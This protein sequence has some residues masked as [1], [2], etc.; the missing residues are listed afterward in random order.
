MSYL[1]RNCFLILFNYIFSKTPDPL[2]SVA[3]NVALH[4]IPL[5]NPAPGDLGGGGCRELP[6]RDLSQRKEFKVITPPPVQAPKWIPG[7]PPPPIQMSP[8]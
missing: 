1:Q 8:S 4:T 7:P 6:Q 2:A 5:N 3:K